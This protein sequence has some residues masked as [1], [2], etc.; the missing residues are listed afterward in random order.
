MPAHRSRRDPID[1]R[2]DV[3]SPRGAS[4]PISI[5]SMYIIYRVI[6]AKFMS[7]RKCASVCI[8][9]VCT[10]VCGYACMGMLSRRYDVTALVDY[11]RVRV[12]RYK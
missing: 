12:I 10:L 7:A 5:K 4:F 9:R 2:R 3:T 11:A 1:D 6:S 8:M